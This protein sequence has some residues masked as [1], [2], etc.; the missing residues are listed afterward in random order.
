MKS[1]RTCLIGAA[2]ALALGCSASLASAQ[3]LYRV[4]YWRS[5]P[6]PV[7]APGTG[8]ASIVSVTNQS[9]ATC[10]VRVSW[11]RPDATVA[12]SQGLVIPPGNHRDFC[13][14]PVPAATTICDATCATLGVAPHEGS[15]IVGVGTSVCS[16]IA[17][18]ART[19]YTQTASGTP[20]SAIT[21]A[22]VVRYG[23]GNNGD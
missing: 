1:A 12:C 4:T 18:S 2:A 21:D 13:T 10:T 19:I 3:A 7:T 22:K 23:G 16:T 15:A 5:D 20:V 11:L 9:A 14:Q 8:S 17:V 6:V